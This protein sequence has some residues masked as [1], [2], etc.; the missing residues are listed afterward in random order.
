MMHGH[1]KE[2]ILHGLKNGQNRPDFGTVT[3]IVSM[4]PECLPSLAMDMGH[5]LSLTTCAHMHQ[6]TFW[7]FR[8]KDERPA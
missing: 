3:T 8:E 7:K 5:D 1:D 4:P 2:S 6:G